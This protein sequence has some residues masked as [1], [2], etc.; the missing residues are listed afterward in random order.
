MIDGPFAP[1]GSPLFI[2]EP[3]MLTPD[4]ELPVYPRLRTVSSRDAWKRWHRRFAEQSI[5][6][7]TSFTPGDVPCDCGRRRYKVLT[8]FEGIDLRVLYGPDPIGDTL[9]GGRA[10]AFATYLIC[11]YDPAP[12]PALAP[13]YGDAVRCH[14][15]IVDRAFAYYLPGHLRN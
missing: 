12:I 14:W 15:E 7:T 11:G 5:V 4:A 9:H 1:P 3:P 6:E 2:L 13:T 10:L 8:R